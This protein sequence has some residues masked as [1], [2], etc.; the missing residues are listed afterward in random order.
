[1][2]LV[3]ARVFGLMTMMDSGKRD[4]K[5]LAVAVDDPEYST[6][7]EA[8]ELPPHRLNMLRRF[9]QDYKTLEG[10]DVAVEEFQPSKAA[11]PIIE[12]AL[13]LYSKLRR[14]GFK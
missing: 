13:A 8:S 2:T 9:F 12:E 10:K 5:I 7:K 11:L 14:Q 1:L 6:F 4:H 3:N